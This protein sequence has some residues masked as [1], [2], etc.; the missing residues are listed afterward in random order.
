VYV[1][2]SFND[3]NPE[4]L[5][6]NKTSTGWSLPVYLADGTH[7]YRFVADKRWFHDTANPQQFPNEFGGLNSVIRI[8]SS[9]LFRL[10]GYP[11]AKKVFLS[12]SFNRWRDDELEMKKINNGWELQYTLGPGNYEYAFIIDGKRSGYPFSTVIQPNYTFRLKGYPNASSV[13][14]AGDFN[15]W[16]PGVLAMKKEGNEWVY[17]VHL[18]AGKHEYKFIVDGKWIID[19]HNKLWEQNNRDNENSIIWINE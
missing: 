3:W 11:E 10:D 4:Q 15:N 16:S 17:S 7:T 2:G 1:S 5:L 19:P 9:Y 18:S 14:L 8:G 12:G 13:F 6:M